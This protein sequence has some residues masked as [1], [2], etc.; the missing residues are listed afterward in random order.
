MAADI[1]V[2]A[3]PAALPV[4]FSWTGWYVGGY[5]G[6]LNGYTTDSNPV[7]PNAGGQ[8]WYVGVIGGY[9]Y[10][11]ANNVVLGI[12]V[13]APLWASKETVS[14]FGAFPNTVKFK[15]GVN[16]QGMVGYAIGRFLPYVSAGIGAARVSAQEIIPPIAS[17]WVTN[18]HLLTMVGFGMQYAV[19]DHW[20]AGVAYNHVVASKETYNCGPVVCG[21]VGQIGLISDTVTG[22]VEYRF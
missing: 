17:P 15:G 7:L 20:I 12:S 2:K 21:V 5:G 1:P 14:I 3:P 10:Q 19:T 11:L 13:D 18:T 16:G 6:Y 4:P 9:R 8:S 22:V